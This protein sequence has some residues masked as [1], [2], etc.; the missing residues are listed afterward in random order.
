MNNNVVAEKI[1]RTSGT[2]YK[3]KMK[4]DRDIML[5][6]GKDLIYVTVEVQDKAGNLCPRSSCMLFFT[7]SG[8]G[9]LKAI[10]NGDPTDQ[11][12]FASNYMRTF[13]GK[14]VV[15]IQST[16]EEGDIELS[17]IGGKLKGDSI[18]VRTKR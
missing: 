1:V 16:K 10:C 13:N 15:I 7:V 14:M 12:S 2:P 8:S 3:I 9:K 17:V 18:T 4:A 11:T 5:A 6:D